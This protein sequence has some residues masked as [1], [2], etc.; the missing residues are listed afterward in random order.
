[1]T[2]PPYPFPWLIGLLLL[3][4]LMVVLATGLDNSL[5]IKL[6]QGSM[7]LG[8]SFWGFLTTLADPMVA[9]LLVFSL[10]HKN[11]LFLRA[12]F[13]TLFLALIVNYS[14][15]YGFDAERPASVLK[16]GSFNLIGPVPLSPSFPSGHTL[17]IFSLMGLLSA[18]Y[19]KHSVSYAV[20]AIASIISLSRISVG[21]H[22]PSDVIFGALLGWIIGWLAI[23]LNKAY[24]EIVDER[25]ALTGYFIALFSGIVSVI[26]KTPYEA[27]QWLSTAVAMFAIAYS[28]KSITELLHREKG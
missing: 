27:G 20:F 15:K 17:T 23:R 1:M 12:F 21:A 3:T 28:L 13:M 22:W 4:L 11:Q 25:I 16:E 14:L 8:D 10:F 19:Q 6:N 7:V 18:W 24:S 9:P 5:F 26:N 2:R